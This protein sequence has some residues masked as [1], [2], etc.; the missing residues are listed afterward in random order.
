MS[1]VRSAE[2]AAGGARSACCIDLRCTLLSAEHGL[3]CAECAV[4]AVRTV[5]RAGS[6]VLNYPVLLKVRVRPKSEKVIEPL[7]KSGGGQNLRSGPVTGNG[8]FNPDG[9]E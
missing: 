4:D 1:R 6:S 5:H 3:H 7:K 2:C 8:I 9:L